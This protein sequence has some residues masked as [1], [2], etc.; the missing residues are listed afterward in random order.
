MESKHKCPGPKCQT[1]VPYR[2]LACIRHWRQVPADLQAQ[3]NSL[4]WSGGVS[5]EYLDA[6]QAAVDSMHVL[7]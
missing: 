1:M 2:H 4:W 7:W 3:V 5:P 6:R